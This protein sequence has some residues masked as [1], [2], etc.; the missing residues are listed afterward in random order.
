M[1]QP[2]PVWRTIQ[3]AWERF[4]DNIRVVFFYVGIVVVVQWILASQ[5]IT[6]FS[7]PEDLDPV[8]GLLA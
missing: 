2:L 3:D 8:T 6:S 7:D 1:A 5:G 4:V